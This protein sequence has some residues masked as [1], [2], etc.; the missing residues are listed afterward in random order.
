L[1]LPEFTVAIRYLNNACSLGA[2]ARIANLAHV[3]KEVTSMALILEQTEVVR[4]RENV[5]HAE[6]QES[7]RL[8]LY[9]ALDELP[10][11]IFGILTVSYIILSLA[12]LVR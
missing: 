5:D 10:G 3:G 4:A 6:A 9:C 1:T 7:T 12:S 8:A 2:D 11:L